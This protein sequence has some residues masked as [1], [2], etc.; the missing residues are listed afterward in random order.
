MGIDRKKLIQLFNSCFNFEDIERTR[1]TS[2]KIS[3]KFDL[4]V[5][6]LV[7]EPA[8]QFKNKRISLSCWSNW[9]L[10]A[11]QI[12]YAAFDAYATRLMWEAFVTK[13]KEAEFIPTIWI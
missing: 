12:L 5:R 2:K 10:T 8:A 1:I 6:N 7:G 13:Y 11:E 9:P 4:L 3:S